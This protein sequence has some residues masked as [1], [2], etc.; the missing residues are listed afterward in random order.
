MAKNVKTAAFSLP[1]EVLDEVNELSERLMISK[2]A[3]VTMLLQEAFRG[4]HSHAARMTL[5]AIRRMIGDVD[6]V[7][8]A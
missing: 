7:N 5:D 6:N 8:E 3:T 2:S 4:G 1:K